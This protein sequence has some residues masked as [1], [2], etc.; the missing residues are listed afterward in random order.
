MTAE[1]IDLMHIR[2]RPLLERPSDIRIEEAAIAPKGRPPES[3][4]LAE[5]P[6]TLAKQIV[7]ARAASASIPS[8]AMMSWP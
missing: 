7:A 4:P 3:R 2:V 5:H 8:S 1:P 6:A